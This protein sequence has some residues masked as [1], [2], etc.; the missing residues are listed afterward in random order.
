[1]KTDIEKLEIKG[2]T[3]GDIYKTTMGSISI[4]QYNLANALSG[5]AF[6]SIINISVLVQNAILASHIAGIDGDIDLIEDIKDNIQVMLKT[7]FQMANE[8]ATLSH[9]K[10]NLQ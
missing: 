9:K 5:E 7:S 10:D 2:M 1:M 3:N 6:S 4:A 8:L